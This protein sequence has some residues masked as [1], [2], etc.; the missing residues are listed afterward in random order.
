ME[1]IESFVH[2]LDL[3]QEKELYAQLR[4]KIK[5]PKGNAYN[6][7]RVV[8]IEIDLLVRPLKLALGFIADLSNI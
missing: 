7:A 1:L 4:R 8:D 6:S 3:H 2:R 5:S